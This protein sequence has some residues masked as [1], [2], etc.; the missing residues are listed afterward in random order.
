MR[1]AWFSPLPPNRSGIAAYSAE[2]LAR[3]SG[4]TI[5]AYV[6]DGRGG[7][8]LA[9][10]AP[11]PG[12]RILGTHDF[13]WRA[14]RE[15]YDLIVYQLGNDLCHDY[16]WPYLVRYPGLVVLHDAQLHQ[17]RAS[18]LLRRAREADYR[19]ELA[20]CHP[21]APSGIADLVISGLGGT[22]YY[23]WPMVRVAVESGRLIAVHN[24]SLRRDLEAAF[25]G[26]A[27]QHV[28][29]GVPDIGCPAGA[30]RA[31][32]RRRHGIPDAAVVFGSF[33][34][35][36]A[37]KGLT[38]VLG[39]L[40]TVAPSMP[41]VRL[42]IVGATPAYFDVAEQA[43]ALG[44]ADRV[45][46][47]GYV[48]DVALPE[49]LEAVD[50]CLNLRWPTA[51]ETSA[52]WL[53][54]LAAGKPTIVSDLAH[55]TDVP[56]LDPRTRRLS[57]TTQPDGGTSEPICLIVALDDEVNMLRLGMAWVACDAGLRT[58]L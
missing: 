52:A 13:T 57:V 3:L 33:G 40:A 29:P 12:V 11:I 26:H 53:R 45:V 2:L 55:H 15:P 18:A 17:S 8:A 9:T 27:I 23:V 32:V 6:D 38:R 22:L 5:D 19:A 4:H 39:A 34:R 41:A 50:V 58:R 49:Y 28:R 47:T 31:E 24:D 14:V 48:D 46:I 35:V 1:L 54:C 51:R 16:M 43:K 56:S 25:P 20:Y 30:A 44:V 10:T 36:T 37:E 7:D 42:L 21:E